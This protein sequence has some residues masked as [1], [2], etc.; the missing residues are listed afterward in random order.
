MRLSEMHKAR[1]MQNAFSSLS[2]NSKYG[3]ISEKMRQYYLLKFKRKVTRE[4]RAVVA[5]KNF[6]RIA[7]IKQRAA[8]NQNPTLGR[9]LLVLRNFL[10]FKAFQSLVHNISKKKQIDVNSK[11]CTYAMYLRLIRKAFYGLRLNAAASFQ[12]KKSKQIKRLML[13]RRW[14]HYLKNAVAHNKALRKM[15]TDAA[16]FRFLSLQRK[17]LQQWVA[18]VAR[19]RKQ[20]IQRHFALTLYHNR[21]CDK[22]FTA[23]KVNH[24]IKSR[25]R[26]EMK[27][28]QEADQG[29][30]TS[31][32]SEM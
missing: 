29:Y 9:P 24:E 28:L 7:L 15:S 6:F 11:L 19:V 31:T 8:M 22:A 1:L 14:F 17:G 25:K 18:Y 12:K 26:L 16:I 10:M 32:S 21:T 2:L 4:W 27:K 5:Q 13:Q 20:K 23:L 3:A 30:L